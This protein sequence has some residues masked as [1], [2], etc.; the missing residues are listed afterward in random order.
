MQTRGLH[1]N[2]KTRK[3]VQCG[4]GEQYGLFGDIVVGGVEAIVSVHGVIECDDGEEWDG[5]MFMV[6]TERK[7]GTVRMGPKGRGDGY[8]LDCAFS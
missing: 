7:Y 3:F 1:S 8:C 6:A 2:D 4:I 5:V